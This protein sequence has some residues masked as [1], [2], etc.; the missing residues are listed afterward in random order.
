MWGPDNLLFASSEYNGGTKVVE[1][2]RNGL[3]T[4]ATER[5]SS[6]R[7]RLHHGNA[8]RIGDAIY[9]S[10][11]GKGSQAMLTAVDARSGKIY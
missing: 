7:L 8:I 10:N 4:K 2:Q 3:Q 11:G 5:W 6:N 9:F 1:L